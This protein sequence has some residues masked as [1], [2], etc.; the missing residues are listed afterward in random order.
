MSLLIAVGLQVTAACAAA[1][2]LARACFRRN[3]AVRYAISSAAIIA[4]LLSP[5]TAWVVNRS[6]GVTLQIPA[7]AATSNPGV[8]ALA[9][10]RTT[11]SGG[12]YRPSAQSIVGAAPADAFHVNWFA[13]V[14]GVW[15]LGALL[16]LAKLGAG[17]VRMRTVA[18][19]AIPSYSGPL[20]EAT[21]MLK[22]RLGLNRLPPILESEMLTGPF[23][24]GWPRPRILI[25][26]TIASELSL[27]QLQDVLAH[28]LAHV[29]QGH[30]L[31]ALGQRLAQILFWPNPLVHLLGRE[32]SR[33]REE[34]CDN[35][36]L[37]TSSG[38]SFAKTL[39]QVAQHVPTAVMYPATSGLLLPRWRLE[40]RVSGLLD[41]KRKVAVRVSRSSMTMFNSGALALCVVAAGVQIT[42]A[43]SSTV[44]IKQGNKT[45]VLHPTRKKPVTIKVTTNSSESRTFRFG[46]G[47]S[48]IDEPQEVGVEQDTVP[49]NSTKWYRVQPGPA[50]APQARVFI[51]R[52]E[53][54]VQGGRVH[55]D[56]QRIFITP[57]KP[58]ILWR[59][60]PAPE[61]P[62][63]GERPAPAERNVT[64]IPMQ[65][66][67]PG[68]LRPGTEP[69]M[70]VPHAD[71]PMLTQPTVPGAGGNGW[72]YLTT[73]E[74][75]DP[76]NRDRV[77]WLRSNG[78]P[79]AA[80]RV[81]SETMKVR[82]LALDGKRAPIALTAPYPAANKSL[83]ELLI[84]ARGRALKESNQSM[85]ENI[86]RLLDQLNSS[87]ERE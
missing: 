2:L 29:E 24:M 60:A 32:L 16:A 3:A 55:G 41:P 6:G 74:A 38:P 48:S 69:M 17:F 51:E 40:Q 50:E 68:A 47:S 61:A 70:A 58:E 11:V 53:P 72:V 25:P 34:V 13:V 76:N 37:L 84:E 46:S 8:T 9:V 59:S 86:Q 81:L 39:L 21:R 75:K 27:S 30:S 64:P 83:R 18:R 20:E 7:L 22:R 43:Q 33:A 42:H 31:L 10:P 36:V 80:T 57:D 19:N 73:P 26:Q 62:E 82:A 65:A 49:R 67:P 15:V 66:L 52:P 45:Y 44:T 85:A 63:P 56:N 4:V 28:E 77:F 12:P 1:L 23:A 87:K 54:G 5:L 14:L 71:A 78:P 79:D 35:F